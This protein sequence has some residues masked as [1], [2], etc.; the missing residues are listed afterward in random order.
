MAATL[1]ALM[2]VKLECLKAAQKA[3]QLADL[4]GRCWAAWR[5]PKWAVQKE[6]SKAVLWAPMLAVH[7]A[8]ST[9]HWLAVQSADWT[10]AM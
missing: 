6:D 10:V 8:E 9:V 2:A 1:A 5:A 7:W 4:T 3:A